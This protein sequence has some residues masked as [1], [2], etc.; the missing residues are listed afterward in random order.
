MNRTISSQLFAGFHFQHVSVDRRAHCF[1]SNHTHRLSRTLSF[2]NGTQMTTLSKE[3]II[4]LIRGSHQTLMLRPEWMKT[5]CTSR[6]D[7]M[8]FWN[9]CYW[10]GL[11][12]LRYWPSS[13]DGWCL[14]PVRLTRLS[15]FYGEQHPVQKK[16]DKIALKAAGR[17]KADME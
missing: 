9:C 16:V 12:I 7:V 17:D 5:W 14:G 4:Y 15:Y 13:H 3:I 8:E 11:W 10:N 1:R 2:C 6:A